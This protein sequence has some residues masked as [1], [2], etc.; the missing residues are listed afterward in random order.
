MARRKKRKKIYRFLSIIFVILV[1]ALIICIYIYNKNKVDIVYD[2]NVSINLNEEFYNTDVIKDSKNLKIITAK[3][4]IDTSKIGEQEVK[5]ETEDNF[6]NKKEYTVKISI[7][8]KEGPTIIYN[9]TVKCLKGDEVN[10]LDGVFATDN[11]GEKVEVKVKGEYDINK[12]GSYKLKYSATDSSGNE[13]V[14]DFTLIVQEEIKEENSKDRKFVTS[15]GY[16]G[17]VKDGITYVEG[18]LIANKTYSLP[19]DYNPGGLLDITKTNADKMIQDS[20]KEGLNIYISS[21]FRSYNRQKTLYTNYVKNDGKEKADTYSAR[22]GHSEHQSGLAFDVNQINSTFDNTEEAKWLHKNCYKYGFILRY[23][24]GK[25]DETGYV[26]ESWHFRYVG[27]ELA[28]KLYNNGDWITMED[29][30]GI[31]SHYE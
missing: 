14:K 3:E 12:V 9:D 8:D 19:E 6:G 22:P 20:K 28:S 5:I 23:P 2:K 29:Y 17:E 18:Y 13:T 1:V 10:L 4:K 21:G 11:T 25:T 7:I 15:K 30:F 24:K 26:Y 27:E 16:K 31:T